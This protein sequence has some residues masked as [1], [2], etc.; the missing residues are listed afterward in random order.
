MGRSEGGLSGLEKN[1]AGIRVCKI[2]KCKGG[3]E[4]VRGER[5]EVDWG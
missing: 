1:G 4:G 2:N 5:R 3:T